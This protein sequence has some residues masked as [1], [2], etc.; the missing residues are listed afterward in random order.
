MRVLPAV[1]ALLLLL[2]GC[3]G[4]EAPADVP[5]ETQYFGANEVANLTFAAPRAVMD[6][7]NTGHEAFLAVS[8][9][10]QTLL[11]CAHGDFRAPAHMYASTDGGATFRELD[12]GPTMLPAGDCDVALGPDGAWSFSGKTGLGVTVATTKDQGETWIINHAAAPPL[13]GLADRQWL[14]YVGDVLLLSYQPGT[15]K[16]GNVLVTR[17]TDFGAT[18]SQPVDAWSFWPL[19]PFVTV[20]DFLVSTDNT[21]IRIPL[22]TEV[23]LVPGAGTFD[24]LVSH[25][26]GLTWSLQVTDIG[27]VPG[28]AYPTGAAVTAG[29]LIAWAYADGTS[30]LLMVSVDDG[31]TWSAPTPIGAG[32]AHERPWASARPDGT[33]DVLWLS[34]G[35]HFGRA[36]GLAVTRIDP[37]TPGVVLAEAIVSD[38]DFIEFASIAHD[39]S[40][41]AH[42]V[43][44]DAP[45]L[46]AVPPQ[47]IE[48][49]DGGRLL[50][51]QESLPTV[52]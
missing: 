44:V 40:G 39:A 35:T 6:I 42:V 23:L 25:D 43:V 36:P 20:G 12:A 10:G 28:T 30:M 46:M 31:E 18:W 32:P 19:L 26:A 49:V 29:G 27:I 24:F 8:S 38:V 41:R 14:A 1:V 50:L 52:S 37:R 22:L 16:A 4:R 9:D 33:V 15:Q 45:R 3:T 11:S 2:A 13:N 34:D 48:A 21:T 7:P 51:V 5:R 17:S 47:A